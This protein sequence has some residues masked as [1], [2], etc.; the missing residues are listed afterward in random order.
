MEISAIF[1]YKFPPAKINGKDDFMFKGTRDF[2]ISGP[3]GGGVSVNSIERG[4]IIDFTGNEVDRPKFIDNERRRTY[5]YFAAQFNTNV[6]PNVWVSN[7]W[8]ISQ[9]RDYNEHSR[10]RMYFKFTQ[11]DGGY[12]YEVVDCPPE[13]PGPPIPRG[14]T[15]YTFAYDI[16]TDE[17]GW[18]TV[19]GDNGIPYGN[20]ERLYVE[21]DRIKYY[22]KYHKNWGW[23]SDNNVRLS[24]NGNFMYRSDPVYKDR[25]IRLQPSGGT[26]LILKPRYIPIP[27]QY[28][29]LLV[30]AAIHEFLK[31]EKEV[32]FNIP[33]L[34]YRNNCFYR[35]S[36]IPA[37]G[38]GDIPYTDNEIQEF[39][40]LLHIYI[41]I[42][43][44]CINGPIP[45][46]FS[47]ITKEV[48]TFI[49]KDS[50]IIHN[51]SLPRT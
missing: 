32:L 22:Y 46:E 23:F 40:P 51:Y 28:R 12:F 13:D 48:I 45:L 34:S 11:M 1:Y 36:P 43:N 19:V 24:E 50:D 6:N 16:N 20:S 44:S 8:F 37:P 42:V 5:F 47:P 10:F 18:Y 21:I 49:N 15:Q 29:S 41:K 31:D 25:S 4:E 14:Y 38:A 2:I 9:E 26:N 17:W 30:L 39:F 3:E 27:K 35:I 7:L 33:L